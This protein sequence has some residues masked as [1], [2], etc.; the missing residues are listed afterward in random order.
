MAALSWLMNMGF[1]ASGSLL[2]A[3]TDQAL[4]G[5]PSRIRLESDRLDAII[6]QARCTRLVSD[7]D[8]ALIGEVSEDEF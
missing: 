3:T 1:A 5:G 4:M 7:V 8:D 2:G 6:G